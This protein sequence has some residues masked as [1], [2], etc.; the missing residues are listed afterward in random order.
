MIKTA[1][2]DILLVI[3]TVK[4]VTV[5]LASITM[6]Q[7]QPIRAADLTRGD[8]NLKAIAIVL[9]TN[10]QYL[11]GLEKYTGHF[12]YKLQQLTVLGF[13]KIVVSQWVESNN[14]IWANWLHISLH[15]STDSFHT[16][17]DLDRLHTWITSGRMSRQTWTQEKSIKFKTIVAVMF[18]LF[19]SSLIQNA[20]VTRAVSAHY[21]MTFRL[22]FSHLGVALW[23]VS[24]VHCTNCT[25]GCIVC[26]CKASIQY[27]SPYASWPI[28]GWKMNDRT[29]RT[30]MA[31]S[32][33]GI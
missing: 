29:R 17:D 26:I 11:F 18:S 23:H 16:M 22:E 31:H 8:P 24:S 3:D 6:N 25:T 1:S 4:N 32:R 28:P 19:S 13:D 12:V 14:P 15:F 20:A 2:S 10:G 27:V 9:A 7:G 30:E 21:K 33:L 5:D